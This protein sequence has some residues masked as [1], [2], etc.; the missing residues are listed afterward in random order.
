MK[1]YDDN[2]FLKIIRDKKKSLKLQIEEL[3]KQEKIVS[4]KYK[5][6]KRKR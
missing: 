3:D 2:I 4:N 1:K 5:M 6:K